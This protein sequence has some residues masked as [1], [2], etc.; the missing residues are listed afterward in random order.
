MPRPLSPLPKLGHPNVHVAFA[1][2][3]FVAIE[4]ISARQSCDLYLK[5]H[6]ESEVP[7]WAKTQS[8]SIRATVHLLALKK[9]FKNY[10]NYHESC[11]T[12]GWCMGRA[13]CLMMHCLMVVKPLV[14]FTF[15]VPKLFISPHFMGPLGQKKYL[16]SSATVLP[17]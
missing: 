2:G 15:K 17:T 4:T 10:M 6:V 13:F 9:H 14:T 8:Y 1:K 3:L 12:N 11:H 7:N 16:V 5:S